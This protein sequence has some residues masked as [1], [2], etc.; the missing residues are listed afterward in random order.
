MAY[1]LQ[2]DDENNAQ[3]QAALAAA[4]GSAAST[5]QTAPI[6]GSG[7]TAAAN[8]TPTLQSDNTNVS[9]GG[10]S[11]GSGSNTAAGGTTATGQVTGGGTTTQQ[12][13]PDVA[14]YSRV[15][16]LNSDQAQQLANSVANQA[17]KSQTAN[18]NTAANQAG[19]AFQTQIAPNVFNLDDNTKSFI[20]GAIQAPQG[21][22]SGDTTQFQSE[23]GGYTG[24]TSLSQDN[25]APLTAAQQTGN[26][27][28]TNLN[29][30]NG[31]SA[32]LQ[33]LYHSTMNGQSP[34]AGE[35]AFDA[36]LLQNNSAINP[37][38]QG[39]ASTFNNN[40]TTA[41]NNL[42]SQAAQEVS[43]AQAKDKAVQ[44]F[45]NSTYGTANTNFQ[46][47]VNNAVTQNQQNY[48]T[49]QK[50]LTDY[51]AGLTPG[52]S[53]PAAPSNVLSTLG[54][55]Q[56]QINSLT[57]A[58][59]GGTKID[60]LTYL[61]VQA[62]TY[63]PNTVATSDQ[64]A[65]YNALQNLMQQPNSFLNAP[66]A[67][68]GSTNY[69]YNNA[70][71]AANV[72]PQVNPTVGAT[73][74]AAAAS[75]GGT[76]PVNVVGNLLG[77][78]S[79]I[80]KGSELYNKI[81][82]GTGE[83]P[84]QITDDI[85]KQGYNAQTQQ[86][87]EKAI[88][89]AGGIAALN[90]APQNAAA[91]A[92]MFSAPA[93]GTV[94]VEEIPQVW[95]AAANSFVPAAS[96]VSGAAGAAGAG[97][98]DAATGTT[99]LFGEASPELGEA[100]AGAGSSAAATGGAQFGVGQAL[101]VAGAAYSIYSAVENYQSGAT[102]P[103]ALNGAMAG[104]STGA[105]VGSIVPGIGTAVGAVVGAVIGGIAGAI[106]SAFG[107]G[108]VDPENSNFEAYTQAYNKTPASGQQIASTV[109]P[110]TVL[111]GLFDLRSG[112]IKGSIPMYNT[113]GRMGEAKFTTDMTSQINNALASG[114][115]SKTTDPATV[116]NSVV[117]PWIN[118]M[119]AWN[120]SNKA[121]ITTLLTQMTADYMNGNYKTRWGDV[122]GNTSWENGIKP[123][124]TNAAAAP[125]AP[126]QQ[127]VAPRVGL[128]A[129]GM[130]R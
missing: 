30:D 16:Q 107:S 47:T 116:Y 102:G 42:T 31:R 1:I 12:A 105:A 86:L 130:L 56:D 35:S 126:T 80:G 92:S 106:S 75:G 61:N 120:D 2:T 51:L 7:S 52:A 3:Q 55:T 53:A 94:T 24:P 123:F 60:P 11:G 72:K 69:D 28:I 66:G 97:V 29:T 90:L 71:A 128:Q 74:P 115:I 50:A 59:A 113:Y 112:Q 18:V 38:F 5:Q 26:Q 58:E 44:D 37:I 43:D 101:G 27:Y 84:Q 8:A 39:A 119:G 93:V 88:A 45:I 89:D 19:S 114:K 122:S 78:I 125:A 81:V 127:T 21:L 111:A 83:T 48:T 68:G 49:Q 67:A 104:A 40:A 15:Q 54:L 85:N 121:A 17:V 73:T 79:A 124:G 9:A 100:T 6:A 87:L 63:N 103:D 23:L 109:D 65:Y 14:T 108:K 96:A 117:A 82:N 77:A 13:S 62:P 33:D 99:T 20:N 64:V 118:S 4:S 34:T 10:A 76:N 25:L 98:S 46:N 70:L 36:M 110:Y 32:A 129:R 95:S 41:Q 57:A 91:L 22:S